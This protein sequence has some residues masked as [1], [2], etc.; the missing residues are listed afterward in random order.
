MWGEDVLCGGEVGFEKVAA[1]DAGE[2]SG[3]QGWGEEFAFALE[4]EVADS[5][6]GEFVALVEKEDF[7]AAFGAGF[8]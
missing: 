3:G 2:D 6:F 7:V 1:E 4:K 5:S 8:S